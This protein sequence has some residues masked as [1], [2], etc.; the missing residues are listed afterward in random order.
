[1]CLLKDATVCIGIEQPTLAAQPVFQIAFG[2]FVVVGGRRGNWR[3]RGEL[4]AAFGAAGL[5]HFP[6]RLGCHACAES[7]CACPLEIAGLECAFHL[8]DPAIL[9]VSA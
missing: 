2:L 7:V 8:P 3:L 4:R 1:M 9:P 6:S 5:Q